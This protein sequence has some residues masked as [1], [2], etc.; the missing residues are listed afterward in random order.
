MLG[1]V[2]DVFFLP[3]GKSGI[4]GIAVDW[5]AKNLYFSN[6]FPH[7][8]Y[9]EACWLD[10]QNR[11]VIYKSTNDN[12]RELAVNPIKKYLYWIDYGQFPMIARSW[13][14]GSHRKAIVTSGISNPRDLAID[15]QTHDVYWVDS[16][17]DAIYKVSY[18][19][20]NGQVIRGNTPSPKGLTILKD[21]VYWVDRNLRNIFKA[22]KLPKQV[23]APN[24]VKTGLDS[25]RDIVFLDPS[26]QPMET[27]NPCKR[28]GNGNCEQLCFSYPAD[29]P[30]NATDSG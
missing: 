11:K 29:A 19:G 7:E 22:S 6:V 14:D 23:A 16:Q 12:P 8:T 27:G 20:G 26:N 24:V 15:I 9:I 28:L 30:E 4:R 18:K 25:L 10:G 2:R 17:K 5:I 1:T 13:L 21:S 3:P